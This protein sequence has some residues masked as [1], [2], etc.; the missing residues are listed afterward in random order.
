MNSLRYKGYTARIDF[1][2]EDDCFIGRILGV[3]DI[4]GFHGD[5]VKELKNAFYEAVD[6]YSQACKAVGKKP[7]KPYSGN[8]MLRIPPEVHA[9]VATAAEVH[10]MSINQ[11]ASDALMRESELH[12]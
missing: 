10:G 2:D 11:W 4:I 12:F 1:S 7:Q 5:T 6:D 8:L 9:A 3:K